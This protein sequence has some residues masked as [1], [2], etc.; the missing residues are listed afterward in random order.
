MFRIYNL[1]FHWYGLIVGLAVSLVWWLVT[2]LS[3][4]F[5]FDALKSSWWL[6]VLAAAVGARVWHLATDW[7]FYAPL[8]DQAQWWR[9]VSVW[10]GGLSI[11]G[12]VLGGLLAI[13]FLAR[14]T[15]LVGFDILAVALPWGQAVGRLANW[16]NQELYGL[17]TRLPWGITID[18]SHR[19]AEVA[20]LDLA[21]KFQPL[22]AYEAVGMVVIGGG[23]W[24]LMA[25]KQLWLPGKGR[26]TWL[27]L[28][29]YSW[30]RFGLDFFR[31]DRGQIYNGLGL[32]QWWLLLV[33]LVGLIY[34][35]N[36][37]MKNSASFN[38]TSALAKRP[39]S[40]L[41][42]ISLILASLIIL[43]VIFGFKYQDNL[44]SSSS[45]N[46]ILA[47]KADLEEVAA[48]W[49]RRELSGWKDL[50]SSPLKLTL[51][52]TDQS[53]N[54]GLGQKSSLINDGMLFN[55][56][57]SAKWQFWMKDMV[58]PLDFV[59]LNDG[60]VVELTR[61]VPIPTGDQPDSQLKIYVPK[62]SVNQMIEL[63]A[64]RVN[65]LGIRVGDRLLILK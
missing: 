34:W 21:T 33:G 7:S 62:K 23:L 53:R 54:L 30:L 14:K 24:W 55:F 61:V 22:F 40:K 8:L 47:N 64:G 18:S 38:P 56:E 57:T 20:S 39:K 15:Y 60:L 32:N 17:P 51:A 45:A 27:Y 28:T 49:Q 25:N 41:I 31:L 19:L 43:A 58:F 37:I 13:R 3:Q 50:S 11:L 46:Q 52:K 65:N 12:A 44:R 35:F 4:R 2:E 10:Q 48:I 63:A 16:A 26:L 6:V 5:K 29:S 1:T 36:Q 9:L 42:W 59:W